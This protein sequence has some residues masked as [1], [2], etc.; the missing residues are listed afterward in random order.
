MVNLER[1][2]QAFARFIGDAG[3]DPQQPEPLAAWH[4]LIRLG[5]IPAQIDDL[6]DDFLR[7]EAA[8]DEE[9]LGI[10]LSREL[11]QFDGDLR[12]AVG[13][14]FTIGLAHEDSSLSALIE[15]AT[16]PEYLSL[17]EF[18]TRVEASSAFAMMLAAP[19]GRAARWSDV[20]VG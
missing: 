5:E 1:L 9:T 13:C 12:G 2:D 20:T 11:T 16:E 7:F 15:S 8:T 4:A 14:D 10:S 18:V 3:S 19:I 17:A 6:G